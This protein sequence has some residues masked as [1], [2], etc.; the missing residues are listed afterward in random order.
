MVSDKL[1]FK[2]WDDFKNHHNL[3]IQSPPCAMCTWWKPRVKTLKNGEFDG[4]VLCTKDGD[5]EH[6]FSC[7]EAKKVSP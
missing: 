3:P 7:F 4:V 1:E 5:M 2:P 6:D